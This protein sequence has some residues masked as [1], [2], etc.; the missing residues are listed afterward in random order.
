MNTH[1]EMNTNKGYTPQSIGNCKFSIPIY[2]RLFAW[3][4]D[5]VETLLK[6][7]LNAFTNNNGPYYIGLMTCIDT[8]EHIDLIDGQ[9]RFTVLMLMGSV[10]KQYFSDWE[11]FIETDPDNVHTRR[12]HFSAREKDQQILDAIC[13]GVGIDDVDNELPIP[14]AASIIQKFMNGIEDKAGFAKYVYENVTFFL[15]LLPDSYNA[16]P[17]SLNKYFEALNGFGKNLEEHEILKVE[18][19]RNINEDRSLMTSIWN[20][21]SDMN[22]T[23]LKQRE[24]ENLQDF[25]TRYHKAILNCMD[26]KDEEIIGNNPYFNED[27]T[28]KI[29]EIEAKPYNF[30]DS[31]YKRE[32]EHG[33]IN[34]QQLLLLV[35]DISIHNSDDQGSAD[36]YN[37]DL[38]NTF[39]Q[40]MDIDIKKFIHMLLLTR[41]CLDYYF[42]RIKFDGIS[43]KYSLIYSQED[44]Y[45]GVLKQFESML[46]V[47]TP[48]YS[49]IR[50]ALMEIKK[51]SYCDNFDLLKI[52]KTNDKSN[53]K[54]PEV[55]EMS[56]GKVDRGWFWRL[57]YYLWEQ[58][59]T[60]FKEYKKE[61]IWSRI[62]NF[63]FSSNRSIE[64]LHPQDE[65]NTEKWESEKI[66]SFGNLAMISQ[67]FNS[68]QSNDPVNVKFARIENQERLES[69]KM[70]RMYL[71]AGK[72]PN[73]WTVEK[74]EDHKKNMYQILQEKY[75]DK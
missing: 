14:H 6:D 62:E 39:N 43:N 19:L 15:A 18:M 40:H 31:A 53:H 61:K 67:S 11:S 32:E 33:V 34:F 10:M 59:E 57:D 47:S 26:N 45:V 4:D 66:N 13:S 20:L 25:R 52:L 54:L 24:N 3:K 2:Q 30:D 1:K 17:S 12:L 23:I 29:G 56:Y 36:F 5:Q 16:N 38:L 70:L 74:M 58:R 71:D 48:F 72:D 73:G 46:Y 7:L 28:E 63:S 68:K 35:L 41:L 49:W 27:N 44:D 64:H 37:G 8:G 75:V 50:P 55:G 42:I 21:S 65:S 60:Y 9:Q 69:L 22:S 51:E